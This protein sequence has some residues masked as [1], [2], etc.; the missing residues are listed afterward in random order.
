MNPTFQV[1]VA[2]YNEDI[3][4]LK[5]VK[6]DYIIYNKGEDNIDFDCVKLENIGREAHTMLYHIIKNFNNLADYTIFLQGDPFF[7][8]HNLLE[9]LDS[10]PDKLNDIPKFS[11]GCY[12]LADDVRLEDVAKALQ[13]NSYPHIIIP[14]FFIKRPDLYEF[15][16]GAQY[17]INKHNIIDKTLFFYKKILEVSFKEVQEVHY[18]WSLERIWPMIF[19]YED[20]Y[21]SFLN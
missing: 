13:C 10:L 17:I 12:Y 4:W 21:E 2:R 1:V 6:L 20:Q 5:N 7:H 19:D 16:N 11:K 9:I 18:P 3:S 14:K 15:A 8:C